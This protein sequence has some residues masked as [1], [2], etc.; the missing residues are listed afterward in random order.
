MNPIHHLRNL[1]GYTQA[2]LAKAANTSE[3]Y[4]RRVEQ[5]LISEDADIGRILLTLK[6]VIDSR[7]VEEGRVAWVNAMLSCRDELVSMAVAYGLETKLKCEQDGYVIKAVAS[8][9]E[10]MNLLYSDWRFLKRYRVANLGTVAPGTYTKFSDLRVAMQA[11]MPSTRDIPVEN[12]SLYAFCIDF[13]IHPY[14]VQRF[15]RLTARPQTAPSGWPGALLT[16]LQTAGVDTGVVR[17]GN[18]EKK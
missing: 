9:Q 2:Q 6:G 11:Y 17:I 10:T 16:A 14:I 12:F 15:E 4:V 1:S 8:I 13:A 3:Q 5:G 7:A 18:M